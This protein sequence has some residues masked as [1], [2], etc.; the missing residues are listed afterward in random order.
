MS[1]DEVFPNGVKPSAPYSHFPAAEVS[2]SC[3]ADEDSQCAPIPGT[4]DPFDLYT[5]PNV[6]SMRPEEP[7][8]THPSRRAFIVSLA[9]EILATDHSNR[10]KTVSLFDALQLDRNSERKV[11]LAKELSLE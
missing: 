11:K 6:D 10:V 7:V 3:I 5:S 4:P 8:A 2:P 1:S 9:D